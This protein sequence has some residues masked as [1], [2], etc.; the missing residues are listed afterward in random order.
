M[1]ELCGN[2]KFGGIYMTFF[3]EEEVLTLVKEMKFSLASYENVDID[4]VDLK[5][6][7]SFNPEVYGDD[8]HLYRNRENNLI[9]IYDPEDDSNGE[10]ELVDLKKILDN[11]AARLT[12]Q[13]KQAIDIANFLSE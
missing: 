10:V 13:K 1:M 11:A 2:F 4:K 9:Y 12:R 5:N 7:V 6:T 3:F 8:L